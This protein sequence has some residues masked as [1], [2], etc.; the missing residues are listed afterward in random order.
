MGNKRR[1]RV[2]VASYEGILVNQH[3]GQAGRLLIYESGSGGNRLVEMRPTPAP[4]SGETRWQKLGEILGDCHTL[5]V[6]G[7][8]ETPGEVLKASGLTV[9]EIEGLIQDALDALKKGQTLRMPRR[10][11]TGCWR[12][13]VGIG[14]GCD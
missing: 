7:I 12:G 14:T 13:I 11:R 4:G 6:N 10:V 9:Y 5:L 8:G 3:L 1:N 2:A